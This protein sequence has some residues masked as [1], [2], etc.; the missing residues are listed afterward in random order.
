MPSFSTVPDWISWENQGANVAVV[1]LDGDGQPEL[2]V[3]RVD[4]P[5]PGPN[6]AFY[7][8]G[9]RID[10]QGNVTGGWR[11][12]IEVPWWGAMQN[13]G[14]G[15][16]VATFGVNHHLVVFQVEHVVPGPNRCRFRLGRN[17]DA[18]GN[19][20]GGWSDWQDVPD[21]RSWRDQGAAIAVADLDADG[22]PE[23]IVFHVDD[24]HGDNPERPNK[25]LY[26][27]ADRSATRESNRP[28]D[29]WRGKCRAVRLVHDLPDRRPR[30]AVGRALDAAF[31]K[32]FKRSG[33]WRIPIRASAFGPRARSFTSI[34]GRYR[35][36]F[37]RTAAISS[38]LDRIWAAPRM[39]S[40]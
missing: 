7:R 31:L 5:V 14:A 15:I 22:Q 25:G 6:R 29:P 3:L 19:V 2:I 21:W 24:L 12:W 10:P 18:Q 40:Q 23:L 16:A 26:R 30:R 32:I 28:Q 9:K 27:V 13:S 8:V 39:R 33:Q 36:E 20:T 17:L 37:S 4:H 1:D 34:P 35:R 11:P 38:C